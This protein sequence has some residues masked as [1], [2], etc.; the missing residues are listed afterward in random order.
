MP[1]TQLPLVH[2][3]AAVHVEPL[4]FFSTHVLVLPQ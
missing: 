1:F 2:W 4:A 3:L